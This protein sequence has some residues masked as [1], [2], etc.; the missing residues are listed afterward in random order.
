VLLIPCLIIVLLSETKIGSGEVGTICIT[1]DGGVV[2]T[3]Q[4]QRK[5][6]IYTFTDNIKGYIDVERDNLIIDGAGYSVQGDGKVGTKPGI[7]LS[8]RSNVTIKNITITGF[9]NEYRTGL[10]LLINKARDSIIESSNIT[11][12]S[13][14]I[15]IY[16]SRNIKVTGNNITNYLDTGIK[17]VGSENISVTDNYVSGG[18]GVRIWS[19]GLS[20][21]N[22]KYTLIS[23]NNITANPY[24]IGLATSLENVLSNNYVARND[25]GIYITFGG[26]NLVTENV[27]M[28]NDRWGMRLSSGPT[29]P[30]NIIYHN[31]FVNNNKNNIS[32]ELQVSNPWFFGPE[33]NTWDNGKEGNY[34]SDYKIRYPGAKE[35]DGSGVWNT[36]FFINPNNIDRYPLVNPWIPDIPPPS[37][38]IISPENKTYTTTNV[39]LTFLVNETAVWLGYRLD[40]QETVT[41]TGNTTLA[42]LSSGLH[43]ITVYA[44]DAFGNTGVSTIIFSITEPIPTTWIAIAAVSVVVVGIGLVVYFRKKRVTESGR[45]VK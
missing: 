20:L 38:L 25:I 22:S 18:K 9:A 29:Y 45:V 8:E 21:F 6:N 15:Y 7:N 10:A 43:N 14:G 5:G 28:D 35:V 40:G 36:A 34:W 44:R 17:V 16:D 30:S 24:G 39:Q 23:R 33:S 27:I 13:G 31:N 42:G 37:V 11:N 12:N 26:K 4:I 41:I 2:G 32:E 19:F 1:A 3:S